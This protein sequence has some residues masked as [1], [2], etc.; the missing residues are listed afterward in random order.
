MEEENLHL[1]LVWCAKWVQT[2]TASLF[3]EK[4][5]WF[6][7]EQKYSVQLPAPLLS[8]YSPTS[9]VKLKRTTKRVGG[10]N[11][12]GENGAAQIL[13]LSPSFD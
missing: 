7:R 2:A 5:Y 12:A 3:V 8:S 13:I 4:W 6:S 1:S 10:E 9:Q 11:T